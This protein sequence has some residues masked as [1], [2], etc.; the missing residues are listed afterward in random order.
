MRNKPDTRDVNEIFK[1]T[2]DEVF[3]ILGNAVDEALRQKLVEK[4]A[5]KSGG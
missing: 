5:Q 3:H 4:G 1:K 2:N